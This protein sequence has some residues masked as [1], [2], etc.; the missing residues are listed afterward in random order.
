MNLWATYASFF[1][2]L[3][4]FLGLG[5]YAYFQNQ[6]VLPEVQ[7][8]SLAAKVPL[9]EAE[10]AISKEDEWKIYYPTVKTMTI[11]Q[12]V[13]QASVAQSWPERI[14]GLSDTPYLPNDIV[15]LFVFDSVGFHSI[16]MKDMNYSIDIIWVDESNKIV[17]IEEGAT[18]ESYP[19]AFVPKIPAKYVIETNENFVADNQIVI[20]DDVVLPNL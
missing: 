10:K 13:V 8:T 3:V 5:G 20:G 2:V 15:K 7:E 14:K 1:V 18:P 6:R 4:L 16:W 12:K 19:A 17:H 9:T 11:G